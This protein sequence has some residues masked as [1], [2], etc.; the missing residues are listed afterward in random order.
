[1]RERRL[2]RVS[3]ASRPPASDPSLTLTDRKLS[4]SDEGDSRAKLEPAATREWRGVRRR[5]HE[6]VMGRMRGFCLLLIVSSSVAPVAAQVPGREGMRLDSLPPL[7]D[8]LRLYG[9]TIDVRFAR[10]DLAPPPGSIRLSLDEAVRLALAQSP[11]LGISVLEAE[12]AANDVTRGNAGFL[13]TLDANARLGGSYADTFFGGDS[14]STSG[15]GGGSSSSTSLG[16]DVTLG[17]TLF[18]GGRRGATLRRLRAEAQR[19]GLSA[20]AEAEAL[21]FAVTAA[22]LDVVRQEGLVGALEEAVVV[23]EDRLRIEQAEVQ[24]GTAAEIDAA[25]A[26]SDLNTD[27]AALLRQALT[28]TQ[29]RATLGA[30]LALPDPEAVAVTD[31]LALGPA[32]DLAVL[33]ARAEGGNRRLRALEVGR[34][35]AEEAVAEVRAEFAP[36]VRAAAGVGLTAFERS[37]FPRDVPA[38]GPDVTYGLTASIP[39][40]DGGE[41]RRRVRNAQLR[42]RQAELEAEDERVGL[43]ADAAR[44]SAAVRGYRQLAALEGQNRAVAREN[45][46]VALAQF[47]LGFIT[48]IDLRQVQL[49]QLDAETRLVDAVYLAERAEAELRLLAG[50]MLPPDVTVV[51]ARVED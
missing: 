37:F 45:V 21:A 44:L 38:V 36:T 34:R 41:R 12:R 17:Y 46:R 32:P 9:D 6:R 29:A 47:Q 31:T 4:P 27:R 28:L 24:I 22:Y 2:R 40:F 8:T 33:A 48:P 26:L 23:S 43:R 16:T 15:G 19:F 42:V 1:M 7:P 13:P 50:E 51:P 39:L 3:A 35:V 30:L 49:A 20:E 10:P 14:D 5:L 11:G 18:D 25:L